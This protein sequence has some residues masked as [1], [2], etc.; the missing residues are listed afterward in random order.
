MAY[1][2]KLVEESYNNTRT[3]IYDSF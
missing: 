1:V 2:N 3:N